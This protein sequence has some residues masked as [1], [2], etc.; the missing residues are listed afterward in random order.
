MCRKETEMCRK[1]TEMCGKEKPMCGKEVYITSLTPL[2]PIS[3][4]MTRIHVEKRPTLVEKRCIV[5]CGKE[6]SIA[7]KRQYL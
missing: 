3:L 4:T 6:T 1:K 2:T 5:I 7:S